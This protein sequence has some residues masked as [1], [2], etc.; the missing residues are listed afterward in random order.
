VANEAC[1]Q[2]GQDRRSGALELLLSTPLS[3][4]KILDGQLM[5]LLRQFAG[6]VVVILLVDYLFLRTQ[7][8]MKDWILTWTAGM[9]VFV[10]DMVALAWVGMW[11][12]LRSRSLHR[13]STA[14]IVRI[15]VLPWM[16]F[17][18][19]ITALIL[20]FEFD[21]G[22]A[23]VFQKFVSKI[24][25]DRIA[26]FWWMGLALVIDLVFISLARMNL[27]NN[28]RAVATGEYGTKK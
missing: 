4:K 27:L 2:I 13:A 15:L 6:P 18:L 28:F 23:D 5:A 26:I 9:I 25:P 19:S 8:R 16:L 22:L 7:Y 17:F 10:V 12:G 20:M 14:A 11:M 24:G 21:R 1:R 3:V